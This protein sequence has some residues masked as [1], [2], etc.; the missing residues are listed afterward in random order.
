MRRGRTQDALRGDAS[1]LA[2]C[3]GKF[4]RATHGREIDRLPEILRRLAT[5]PVLAAR[6]P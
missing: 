5:F 1:E 4:G 3:Y 6:K 2:R